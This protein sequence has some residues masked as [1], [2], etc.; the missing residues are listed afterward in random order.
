MV[1][2]IQRLIVKWLLK[3]G[4]QYMHKA[5]DI[6]SRNSIYIAIKNQAY[7][8]LN[9]NMCKSVN[10]FCL[11][12]CAYISRAQRYAKERTVIDIELKISRG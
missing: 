10:I 12:F 6:T 9:V 11:P 1:T 4:M 8:N 5:N 2:T 3:F 7:K